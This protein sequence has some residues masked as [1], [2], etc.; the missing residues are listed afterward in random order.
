M[1]FRTEYISLHQIEHLDSEKNLTM[2]VQVESVFYQVSQ[3]IGVDCVDSM[4]NREVEMCML[5]VGGV[6]CD[7]LFL[8]AW[9]VANKD[10]AGGSSYEV[11][12]KSSI[13][14]NH[15]MKK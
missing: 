13:P 10:T 8:L 2:L 11:W 15:V 14:D 12:C 6:G 5:I 4:G 9:H 1:Q 7:E 3:R